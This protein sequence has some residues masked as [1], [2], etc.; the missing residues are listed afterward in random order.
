MAAS[1]SPDGRFLAIATADGDIQVCEM[2]SGRVLARWG[3]TGDGRISTLLFGRSSSVLVSAGSEGV[4]RFWRLDAATSNPDALLEQALH[5]GGR[6]LSG[7]ELRADPAWS[8]TAL[9]AIAN[10]R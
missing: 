4:I 7:V 6:A 1:L 5:Q 8:V 3:G 9:E 2:P 10:G